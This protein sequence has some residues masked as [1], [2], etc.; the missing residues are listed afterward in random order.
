MG[1]GGDGGVVGVGVRATDGGTAD[2]GHVHRT[3]RIDRFARS[4]GEGF[5]VGIDQRFAVPVTRSGVD[6][7][8]R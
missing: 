6:G 7:S 2:C 5:P 4:A 3:G 1:C 8:A